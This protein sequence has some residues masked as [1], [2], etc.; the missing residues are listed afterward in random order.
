MVSY[1]RSETHILRIKATPFRKEA[2]LAAIY[3]SF[4]L[5]QFIC[6]WHGGIRHRK[7]MHTNAT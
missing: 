3:I 6:V 1:V 2:S 5:G 4:E 7:F